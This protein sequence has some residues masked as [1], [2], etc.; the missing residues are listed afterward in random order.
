MLVPNLNPILIQTEELILKKHTT[1]NYTVIKKMTGSLVNSLAT[2]AVTHGVNLLQAGLGPVTLILGP[3]TAIYKVYHGAEPLDKLRIIE[4]NALLNCT[5]G[6][7]NAITEYL[8]NKRENKMAEAG[9]SGFAAP[10]V[11]TKVFI[12]NSY[13]V[14]KRTKGSKRE[15]CAKAL[16]KNAKP[17]GKVKPPLPD[18]NK[19]PIQIIKPIKK[20]NHDIIDECTSTGFN[21]TSKGCAVAQGLVA[22]LMNEPTKK[23]PAN[24]VTSYPKTIAVINA[25]NGWKKVKKSMNQG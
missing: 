21:I 9:I 12:R 3:L 23:N 22:F 24:Q 10:L 4:K 20:L 2:K 16:L 15:D 1:R 8:I 7:C 6:E 13:K 5:C 17:K 14:I 19:I 18:P 25:L 11:I